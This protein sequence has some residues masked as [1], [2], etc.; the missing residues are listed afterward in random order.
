M[1]LNK[2]FVRK[3]ADNIR[4]IYT[5]LHGTGGEAVG[6]VFNK[7]GFNNLLY[8]ESQFKPSSEFET[9]RYPNPEE[10]EVFDLAIKLGREK[11][12]DILL[13]SDP[14]CDRVGVMVR[15]NHGDYISLTG[16][17][18][19]TLLTYY[20]LTQLSSKGYID[21][22]YVV[23]KTIVTTDIVK[24]ICWDFN[25]QME[26]VLTGFKYIGEKIKDYEKENKKFIFGFEESYG[27]LAGDFVRD[28]DGVIASLLI[29]EMALYYKSMNMNLLEVLDKIYKKYGYYKEELLSFV[30][31]GKTGAN[32]IK[33]IMNNVRDGSFLNDS[34]FGNFMITD[35]NDGID[36]LPSEDV[37]SIENYKGKITIRPS[38]TE[39]KIKFYLA[40]RSKTS[41]ETLE[42]ISE[43]RKYINNFMESVHNIED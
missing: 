43:F 1:S 20:I 41:L 8:V 18:I 13:A 2:E 28:K 32:T 7:L 38:G 22:S 17:E 37:V 27:Y 11:L 36:S 29:S 42:Y 12:A 3:Y 24:D 31:D 4:I 15:N 23:V 10:K 6:V 39:P 33:E 34:G 19:G 40:A 21:K 14:D 9:I 30:L 25:V 16:N 5:P 26:E 35:Y